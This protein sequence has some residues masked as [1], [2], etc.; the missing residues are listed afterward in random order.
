MLFRS[1]PNKDLGGVIPT[2]PNL[3]GQR[4]INLYNSDEVNFI[5]ELN[6]INFSE[7]LNL[8]PYFL[9]SDHNLVGIMSN[10]NYE[11]ESKLFQFAANNIKNNPQGPVLSRLSRNIEKTTNGRVR[12]LDALNGNTTTAINLITGRE[13]LVDPNYQITVAKTLPGKAID[14]LEVVAGVTSPFSEIPGDYLSKPTHPGNQVNYRPEAKT[15][16]GK[17]YQDVT[18][19]LGSLIGIQRRPTRDRKP[20]DVLIEHTSQGQ[21]NRL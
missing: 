18:G 5:Q 21:K 12:L 15:E 16:L 14:L 19:A 13:P 20:S 2:N 11:T 1:V 17:I 9:Y 3:N 8:Y 7:V 4:I 10:S 6:V